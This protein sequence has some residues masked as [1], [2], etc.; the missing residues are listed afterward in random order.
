MP[1]NIEYQY[2]CEDCEG[3]FTIIP[4]TDEVIQFCPGC[5]IEIG[6]SFKNMFNPIEHEDEESYVPD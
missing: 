2:E 6:N 1:N 4:D 3:T 5:G